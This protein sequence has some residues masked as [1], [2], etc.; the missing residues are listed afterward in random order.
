MRKFLFTN[1]FIFASLLLF[2]QSP[3]TKGSKQINLGVGLSEFAIPVYVGLDYSIHDDISVG[4]EL[5]YRSY[6]DNKVTNK[7][8]V[9]GI[10]GNGNYHF[11][12]LLGI[13]SEWDFYGGLNLGFFIWNSNNTSDDHTSGIGL[14]AQ[15][16][17]RYYFNSKYGINLEFSGGNTLS[18]GKFGLSIRL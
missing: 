10:L 9:I 17:G 13:P 4:G 18:E 14:G 16:G 15:I 8:N 5:S 3:L 2:A 11:N 1:I 6:K 12:N 7:Y